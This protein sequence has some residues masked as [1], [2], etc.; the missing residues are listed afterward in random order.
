MKPLL[1]N[2]QIK[3]AAFRLNCEP[4][5]LEAVILTESNG[6]GFLPDGKPKILYEPFVFGR[7][8]KGRYN[9]VKLRF[10]NILFPLSLTGKWVRTLA[11]YGP[12]SIQHIKLA[13]AVK[14]D[15]DS[16]YKACSWGKFQILGLNYELCGYSALEEFVTDMCLSEEKHLEAFINYVLSMGLDVLLRKKD[17][18]GF[19]VKYNGSFQRLN[20]YSGKLLDHYNRLKKAGDEH[21]DKALSGA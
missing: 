11:M 8:T 19:A 6:N 4:E 7:L 2:D 14:L 20:N 21:R 3:S 13:E 15:R 1:T 9:G 5:A 16:A 18:K 10:N 17:W 12:E